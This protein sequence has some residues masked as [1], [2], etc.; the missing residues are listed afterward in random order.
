MPG[1]TQTDFIGRARECFRKNGGKLFLVDDAKFNAAEALL[2]IVREEKPASLLLIAENATVAADLAAALQGASFACETVTRSAQFDGFA[3]VSGGDYGYYTERAAAFRREHPVLVISATDE[4]GAP[5]LNGVLCSN[6]SKSGMYYSDDDRKQAKYCVSDFLAACRYE[7]VAI[8]AVFTL[9][10]F[11][12]QQ[13]LFERGGA[14]EGGEGKG[15]AVDPFDY[16]Y[17]DFLGKDFYTDTA[18]SFHRLKYIAGAAKQCVILSDTVFERDAVELYAVLDMLHD[19]FNFNRARDLIRGLTQD[20]DASCE[21]VYNDINNCKGDDNVLSSCVQRA[22]NSAQRVPRDISSMSDYLEKKLKFTSEE[23]IFLQ[24]VAAY[25]EARFGG[26]TVMLEE[27]IESMERDM[28]EMVEC[29]LGMYLRDRVKGELESAL[30]STYLSGM[31][32]GEVSAL[33]AVFARYGVCHGYGAAAGDE[34]VRIY[35]DD[36]AFE[37]AIREELPKGAEGDNDYAVI[38]DGGQDKFKCFAIFRLLAEKEPLKLASPALVIVKDEKE[39]TVLRL[40]ENRGLQTRSLDAAGDAKVIV[41]GY[42]RFRSTAKK[43]SVASAIFYDVIPD[44]FLFVRTR[45]KVKSLGNVQ[46]AVLCDYSDLGGF[47]FGT[48]RKELFAEPF[49]CIPFGQPQIEPKPGLFRTYTDIAE[50]I[51]QCYGALRE[52][53]DKGAPRGGEFT[54]S[55]RN[56]LTALADNTA[57]SA[58]EIETDMHFFEEDAKHMAAAFANAI[59]LGRE[60]VAVE[61]R[62][63]SGGKSAAEEAPRRLFFN[64]CARYLFRHCDV[65]ERDCNGCPQYNPLYINDFNVFRAETEEFFQTALAYIEWR[66]VQSN[67]GVIISGDSEEGQGEA[68]ELKALILEQQEGAMKALETLGKVV[69]K[70][71]GFASVEYSDAEKALAPMHAVAA[72]ILNKYTTRLLAIFEKNSGLMRTVYAT[73]CGG[74]KAAAAAK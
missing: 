23:E 9:L 57:T 4:A 31:E 63:N 65:K 66:R 71:P 6:P 22:Q 8:D 5:L 33:Y 74:L 2:A 54:R 50:E 59:T 36:S 11:R 12:T 56:L 69:S 72:R 21:L 47:L 39:E 61:L 38:V 48:W 17:V 18:H 7:F 73:A 41:A 64:V 14:D 16:D 15:S 10:D 53:V 27:L 68:N 13:Q 62:G 20:Y 43:P 70:R 60:G 32:A 35:R 55:Y 67:S 42:S 24:A 51:A 34:V 25:S 26:K 30:K 1:E 37:Y 44:L 45:N 28:M 52:I 19:K 58:S 46:T 3:G 49:G 40:L 29:F